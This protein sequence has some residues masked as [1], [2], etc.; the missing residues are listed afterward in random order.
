MIENSL[1]NAEEEIL[2]V[3]EYWGVDP[4]S[5][6]YDW[7]IVDFMDREEYM[8]LKMEYRKPNDPTE[9]QPGEIPY[10]GPK[11]KR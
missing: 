1:T 5:V 9:Y 2:F 7:T 3:A 6:T 8:W 4:E 10:T 11:N